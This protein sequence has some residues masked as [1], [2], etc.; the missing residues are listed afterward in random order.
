MKE[1]R[2]SVCFCGRVEKINIIKKR[3]IDQRTTYYSYN[4]I[5]KT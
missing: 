2:D 1:N 4:E 3:Q 5:W